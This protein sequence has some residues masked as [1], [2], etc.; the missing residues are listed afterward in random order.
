MTYLK[1]NIHLHQAVRNSSRIKDSKGEGKSIHLHF[2]FT[3]FTTKTTCFG[4][5]ETHFYIVIA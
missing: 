5:Q 3:P 1:N 2:T 4:P